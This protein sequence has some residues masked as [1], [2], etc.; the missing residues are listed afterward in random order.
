[1]DLPK[2]VLLSAACLRCNAR[3]DDSL[4]SQV[5]PELQTDFLLFWWW[6]PVCA[7]TLCYKGEHDAQLS[8]ISS[9]ILANHKDQPPH[10][11][12]VYHFS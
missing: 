4:V 8:V 12:P 9:I 5:M 3:C 7:P 6:L 11:T 10:L 1:M 2:I